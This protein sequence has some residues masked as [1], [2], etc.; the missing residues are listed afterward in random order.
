MLSIFSCASGP[1]VYL[2]WRD[3]YL[4]L[5]LSV[6]LGCFLLSLVS[7]IICLCCCCS[8]A[9]SYPTLCN[10]M[11]GSTPGSL[12]LH[13][14]PEFAQTQVH[15]VNDAIQPSHPLSP[16]PP[17]RSFPASVFFPMNW[18]FASGGLSIGASA[19][20]SVLPINIQGWFPLGLTSLTYLLSKGLSRVFSRTTVR[21]HHFFST[22]LSLWSNSHIYYWKNHSFNY[23]DPCQQSDVSAF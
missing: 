22:Q 4:D 14:I 16:S 20:A 2:L 3:V 10:P 21:K 8:V 23:M 5:L 17:S 18:L 9:Q 1:S 19:S 7:C 13:C 6:W 12:I 11:D 15:W